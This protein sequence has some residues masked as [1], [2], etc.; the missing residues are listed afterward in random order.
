MQCTGVANAPFPG[1]GT[2]QLCA[3]DHPFRAL[4]PAGPPRIAGGD[5]LIIGSGSYMIGFGAPGAESCEASG[6]WDCYMS[7]VP[8]GPDAANPTRILGQGWETGSPSPP[9][10]WGTERA[11]LVLNLTDASNVDVRWLE[12][13]DHSGC[14]EF[15]TGGLA[16]NRDSAP[17]GPWAAVG[18]YAEDSA[19]VLLRNLNIHGLAD[20]GIF[21]G[22]LTDWTLQDV[23]IAANGWVG[24]DGDL[25]QGSDSNSGTLLFQRWTVEWNGC[26][27]TWPGKQPAGCWAQ[28]AG[29]Y[30]DG[31]G[32]GPTSGRW[33]IE[34]SAFL[35]NTSDGL[36]L[37]YAQPGASIQIRRTIAEGNAGNQIK[38]TG[39]V[40][41]ENT[42]IV[43]NC[44]FFDGQPFTFNV[45]NCRALGTALSLDLRRGD[46]ATVANSTLTSEG[47]CL[48]TAELNGSSDG[49]ESVSLRNNIF[50]GQTDFLQ[51]FENTCLVYEETF[52]GNPFDVDYSVIATV[53]DDACPGAHDICGIAPGLFDASIAA[54]DAHLI[55]GSVAIDSG[56]GVGA[57]IP[58]EDYDG[59]ARP[60]GP[61]VDRGAYEKDASTPAST[62]TPT[63]T[64]TQP[65]P[66][67]ATVSVEQQRCRKNL[68]AQ[69][70]RF[71]DAKLAAMQR[72]V[73]GVN[74][75][76]VTPPCP[77][78]KAAAA[79]ARAASRVD[80]ATIADKCPP[81]VIA[82]LPLTG[83]CAGATTAD[84][85]AVCV[86]VEAGA[87]VDALLP[88][89]YSAPAA[90]LATADA[91]AC[92]AV[93]A[94]AAGKQY[95]VKRTKIFS[96]CFAQRDR[97]ALPWCPDARAAAQLERAR[98]KVEPR[99]AGQC[100]DATIQRL[101]N[102]GGFGGSC[103][104]AAMVAQLA[105]CQIAEHDTRTDG[106]L[107]ILP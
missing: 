87:A 98:S 13:T 32:T 81:G 38:T 78:V 72:C 96:T 83:S 8:S 77:D 79:V 58:A 70:T 25:W 60:F 64:A 47:D 1:S 50:Q 16:C 7:P 19:N 15:H 76:R 82:A 48:V 9:E 37:L 40:L 4:P 66:T 92:Q 94:R 74:T 75:G 53:K 68:R 39:P 3:W 42:I 14:V 100:A 80:P 17:F 20:T 49:S 63:P 91:Q 65:P 46:R 90:P 45:D 36:D 41:I 30:G 24:W 5:T 43:G 99:I 56:L 18:L 106:L 62:R 67:A 34:D 73:A 52:M 54:F 59:R 31:V 33:I 21:A 28:E 44:G 22:R 55:P 69:L 57:V 101:Q 29:G 6:A 97:G 35:H 103:A 89:E 85:L 88:V 12:I 93:I 61:G 84:D 26:G 11:F 86:V 2:A 102:A 95:A 51:P 104:A 107:S 27:E 71:F 23:R 105:A 10:L